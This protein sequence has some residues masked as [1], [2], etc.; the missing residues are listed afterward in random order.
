MPIRITGLNSGLDTE[1]LVSE[2]VSAYRTKEQKYEKAQKKLSWKQDA[3]KSLN[4]K[5]K[6]VYDN[7][8]NLRFSSAW[9]AKKT[10]VSD[11]T[12]ATITAGSNA[13]NGTHSLKIKQLAKGTYITSGELKLSNAGKD[14]QVS[15]DT[16]LA[17]LGYS[18][19]GESIDIKDS[20]G[21]VVKSITVSA[22]TKI[23]DV[24]TEL[25]SAGNLNASFDAANQ[26]IFV[27]A[28]ETGTK[29]AFSLDGSAGALKALG[30]STDGGAK[31]IAAQDSE[32]E[33]DGATFT[34]ST[35]KYSINGLSIDCLAETGNSEISITTSR[36]TEAMYDQVKEFISQ[37]NSIMEEMTKLYNA[38]SAKGY[39]PLTSEEKDALTDTEVEEWEKKIKDALLR[40]D[41]TLDGL[42]SAMKNAMTESCYIYKGG[43]VTFD[44]KGKYY[45]CNGEALKDADG[46]TIT[47]QNQLQSWASKNGAK[48]YS[49]ASFGIMTEAYASMTSSNTKNS[50]HINGD[51]DDSVSK[52]NADVLMN[53][54]NSDP[55]TV[56]AFMKQA[57]SNLY[58][59]IDDKMKSVKGLSSAYTIYNDI[60]MAQE[61]SDYT[62][63]IKKWEDK[64]TDME[65][66]YYKKFAAME[67]ALASLQS[68][69]SSLTSLLS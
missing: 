21:V 18:G 47:T 42:M 48:R 19:S 1:A 26:R 57:V 40:R 28:N 52:N 14:E 54:L 34:S 6:S 17:D 67:S 4:T 33:L 41:D 23:S 36:D 43:A 12:K 3:W 30:L 60:E 31:E 45:K 35:N 64:V 24:L 29:N 27:S 11:A 53:M 7:I 56:A 69:S 20:T 13:V 62:D 68:Q 58:S 10:T 9:S 63:T 25:N 59:A 32:I 15:A 65:D 39:E 38:D 66:A 55:D 2:L 49:L 51:E 50:Y 22:K 16:T 37:Y 44:S 46:N 5:V 8:S 61:Y